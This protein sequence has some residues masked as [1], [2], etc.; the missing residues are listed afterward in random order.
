MQSHM[1][2]LQQQLDTYQS[3]LAEKQQKNEQLQNKLAKVLTCPCGEYIRILCF[4]CL[5][6]E[7]LP[8]CP[9]TK[10]DGICSHLQGQSRDT[11]ASSETSQDGSNDCS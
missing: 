6:R 5:D 7:E 4:V 3:M 1:I 8:G 10:G 2:S 11:R 9:C